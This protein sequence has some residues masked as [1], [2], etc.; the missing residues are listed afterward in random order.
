MLFSTNTM[1]VKW[2]QNKLQTNRG[3]LTLCA[4]QVGGLL[5]AVKCLAFS[6]R[7]GGSGQ[8]LQPGDNS[9]G[10]GLYQHPFEHSVMR[11]KEWEEPTFVFAWVIVHHAIVRFYN[12]EPLEHKTRVGYTEC[13]LPVSQQRLQVQTARYNTPLQ[14]DHELTQTSHRGCF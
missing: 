9:C 5:G 6:E 3:L 4:S 7:P 10:F 12:P 2:Q 13:Y 8:T 1:C 11:P 14:S